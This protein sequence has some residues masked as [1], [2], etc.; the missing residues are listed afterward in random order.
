MLKN[1]LAKW[2][3]TDSC[4]KTYYVGSCDEMVLFGEALG[5]ALTRP[6]L[7]AL[8]G[9]LGSGK[10]TLA[11]GIVKGLCGISPESVA[12]PTFQ[13][14]HFYS[15]NHVTV[16]HFDLWRMKDEEEFLSLGLEEFL[17]SDLALIE[18]P[19]R[20]LS[21]LPPS[22]IRLEARVSGF[23]REITIQGCEETHGKS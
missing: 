7:L 6:C 20:I 18:W 3:K 9:D 4:S 5:K 16:V 2:S 8:S 22:T 11:K 23:G 1:G 14:V 21:L 12:S 10:T 15:G 19:E 13:Y 17:F